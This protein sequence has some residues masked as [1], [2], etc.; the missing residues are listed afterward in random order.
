MNSKGR[1]FKPDLYV[2]ARIIKA[3]MEEGPL[4]RTKLSL[5]SDLSYDKFAQY[6]VWLVSKEIL[7]ENDGLL[8]V[9]QQGMETYNR[10]VEW[11]LKYV[12]K[13]KFTRR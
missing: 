12:G 10:L 4:P 7:V 2:V 13:L 6:M 1:D 8:H 9:T 5:Y 11:I 3:L